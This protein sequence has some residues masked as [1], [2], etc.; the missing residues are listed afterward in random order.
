MSEEKTA[1]AEVAMIDANNLVRQD[2]R[3][4]VMLSGMIAA[5]QAYAMCQQELLAL[6]AETNPPLHA[7]TMDVLQAAAADKA[8]KPFD[9]SAAVG[10]LGGPVLE[11]LRRLAQSRGRKADA[12][13]R[14][15]FSSLEDTRRSTPVKVLTGAIDRTK[16]VLLSGS[17]KFQAKL[18]LALVESA[19]S[20]GHRVLHL[21]LGDVTEKLATR[22]TFPLE[23]WGGCCQSRT[24][25]AAVA[26]KLL[27]PMCTDA[28]PVDIVFVDDILAACDPQL[29][30]GVDSVTKCFAMRS[31]APLSASLRLLWGWCK[32]K[33]A[34]LVVAAPINIT[35]DFEELTDNHIVVWRSRVST[36]ADG[37]FHLV[38][39]V[40]SV[41]MV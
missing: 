34:A 30:A 39:P 1:L 9:F 14:Q 20:G 37:V 12:E 41:P 40:G 17:S 22:K 24:T 4:A 8:S 38:C 31:V 36:G 21:A 27:D 15:A 11:M 25:F 5:R 29:T 18:F 26:Q 3:A 28:H 13:A 2:P 33:G 32:Y 23:A 10:Q 7:D 16:P 19:A 6:L 35:P